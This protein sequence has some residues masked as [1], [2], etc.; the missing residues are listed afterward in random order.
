[1]ARH[2][3]NRAF[4]GKSV[5]QIASTQGKSVMDAFLDLSLAEE[6]QT[7]FICVDRNTEPAAQ[8]RILSSPIYGNRNKRRWRAPALGGPA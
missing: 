1:M 4:E 5:T 3:R 7:L 8:K 6:L 2:Q